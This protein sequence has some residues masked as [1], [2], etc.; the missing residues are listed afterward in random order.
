MFSSYFQEVHTIG[1]SEKETS[2]IGQILAFVKYI[3]NS[4]STIA[5]CGCRF[6]KG[7]LMIDFCQCFD[8][9]FFDVDWIYRW[10][11][12]RINMQVVWMVP[13]SIFLFL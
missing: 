5:N 9:D 12:I 13:P 8:L 7:Q 6:L 11:E 1:C 3:F 2:K 4:L 10:N